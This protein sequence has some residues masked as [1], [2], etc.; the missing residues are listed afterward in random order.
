MWKPSIYGHNG[1]DE[2]YGSSMGFVQPEFFLLLSFY[3]LFIS[4]H[5]C[6]GER[7]NIAQ[8]TIEKNMALFFCIFIAE[9]DGVVDFI[10]WYG[11]VRSGGLS[12]T[13][14]FIFYLSAFSSLPW[15]AASSK[16]SV[17]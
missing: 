15:P 12:L 1:W 8:K 9:R 4:F 6:S 5:Q 17:R 2:D 3:L 13:F 16:Y 11:C 7:G 10:M 14:I